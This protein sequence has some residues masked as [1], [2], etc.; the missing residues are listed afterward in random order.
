MEEPPR[1]QR[2][3]GNEHG[4]AGR[5][6]RVN[7]QKKKKRAKRPLP[8]QEVQ[9]GEAAAL[10]EV[11]P[12]GDAQMDVDTP[13]G[14]ADDAIASPK[15]QDAA[16][17]P[18]G[19][20]APPR[21]PIGV[22]EPLVTLQPKWGGL[23]AGPDDGEPSEDLPGPTAGDAARDPTDMAWWHDPTR[24]VEDDDSRRL[25]VGET[26]VALDWFIRS[27]GGKGGAPFIADIE[28]AVAAAGSDLS[29]QGPLLEFFREHADHYTLVNGE[30]QVGMVTSA[31]ARTAAPSVVQKARP[32]FRPKGSAGMGVPKGLGLA[33]VPMLRGPPPRAPPADK[34]EEAAVRPSQG[35]P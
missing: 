22:P 3:D 23:P 27:V 7:R 4:K 2:G 18:A 19:G 20:T 13:A 31:D 35:G 14:S 32:I 8:P 26:K 16:A 21:L 1:D 24:L 29:H 15:A 28:E 30:T 12:D 6:G 9:D 33:P 10:Q 17:S 11:N 5:P 25:S 34:K